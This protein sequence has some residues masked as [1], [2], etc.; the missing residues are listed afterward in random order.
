MS[1]RRGGSLV[2]P[3]CRDR[4]WA[5]HALEYPSAPRRKPILA[6]GPGG[7]RLG[8]EPRGRAIGLRPCSRHCCSEAPGALLPLASAPALGPPI[9]RGEGRRASAE[10]PRLQM[11]RCGQ[12]SVFQSLSRDWHLAACGPRPLARPSPCPQPS[13]PSPFP[14]RGWL[15]AHSPGPAAAARDAGP[16]L[17]TC[18]TRPAFR[19]R[20]WAG[21]DAGLGGCPLPWCL[22]LTL[23][24]RSAPWP[25]FSS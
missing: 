12:T 9:L 5:L 11:E 25:R 18:P 21:A 19:G 24:Q 23:S 20:G 8:G 17:I 15:P 13:G 7:Q 4:P 16:A 10:S 1:R 3:G 22:A 2:S 6:R 14:S